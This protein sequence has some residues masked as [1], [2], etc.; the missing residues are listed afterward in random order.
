[1]G[2]V[3]WVYRSY[4]G[5]IIFALALL[6]ASPVALLVDNSMLAQELTIYSFLLLFIGVIIL[7]LRSTLE[8]K[9]RQ[10]KKQNR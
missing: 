10:E 6:V 2:V 3:F 8:N 7:I 9:I 5:P 1:M 4:L